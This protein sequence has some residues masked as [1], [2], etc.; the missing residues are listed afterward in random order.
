MRYYIF[1]K[2]SKKWTYPN[3]VCFFS[4]DVLGWLSILLSSVFFFLGI[5]KLELKIW[6]F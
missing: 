2:S 5:L 6:I 3:G 1:K 4:F